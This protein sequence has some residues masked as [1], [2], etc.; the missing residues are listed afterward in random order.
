MLDT[1]SIR[2]YQRGDA[3]A[4]DQFLKESRFLV[5]DGSFQGEG[6]RYVYFLFGQRNRI[7]GMMELRLAATRHLNNDDPALLVTALGF[8]KGFEDDEYVRSLLIYA[9]REAR[10]VQAKRLFLLGPEVPYEKELGYALAATKGIYLEGREE[11]C[12]PTLRVKELAELPFDPGLL[13]LL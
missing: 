5:G 3:A 11:E 4:L 10:K 7:V 1:I 2:P 13:N 8:A 12:I 6:R 9:E